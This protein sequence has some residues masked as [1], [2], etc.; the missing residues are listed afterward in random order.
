MKYGKYLDRL[1]SLKGKN[2]I[3]TGANSGL[4]FQTSAA[5]CYKGAHLIMACRNQKK[6]EKAKKELLDQFPSA[7]I[8]LIPYD[9]SRLESILSFADAIEKNYDRIDGIV[10]NAG[11]YFPKSHSRTEDG[12]E[13]TFGTNYLGTYRLWKR[14]NPLLDKCRARVV[15]VSSLT[16][17][18]SRRNL[19]MENVDRMRRN[20]LYGYSKRCL[21]RLCYEIM[22]QEGQTEVMVAHPGLCKTNIIASD[23][24]GFPRWFTRAGHAFLYLF[25]HSAEKAALTNLAAL[26][27]EKTNRMIRPRGLFALSGYPQIVPM[28]AY[29]KKP[30]IEETEAYLERREK[31]AG[32]S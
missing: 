22:Q 13:L 7:E 8:D 9:Q 29:S 3:V 23:Q 19:K 2:I 16:A 27:A 28:P 25:T 12:F 30:V 14:L 21:S 32:N 31:H 6:G 24:T 1:P 11:I 15:V 20:K 10:F 26:T 17:F 5:L 18:F 4:G